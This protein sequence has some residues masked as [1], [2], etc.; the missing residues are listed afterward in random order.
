MRSGSW[1]GCRFLLTFG[2]YGFRVSDCQI[3][4]EPSLEAPALWPHPDTPQ[5][6][7]LP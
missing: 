1:A 4:S 3:L 7:T 2:V 5:A 6:L